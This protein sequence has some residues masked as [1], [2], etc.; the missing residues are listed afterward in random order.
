MI[1]RL[2]LSET[3]FQRALWLVAF[4]FAGFLIGLGRLVVGD[5]Q[6]VAPAVDQEAFMDRAQLVPIRATLK[7]DSDALADNQDAIDR[8]KLAADHAANDY[9]AARETFDNWVA[10]RSATAQSNEN[11]EVLRRTQQLDQLKASERS[12]EKKTEDL[13]QQRLALQQGNQAHQTTL[14]AIQQAGMV[15]Y[16]K[17]LNRQEMRVFLLRLALTLPLL[18]ISIFLFL[19]ARQSTYWPFVWGFILFSLFSFFVEL[20]PYLPSYGGYVRYIVGILLTVLAGVYAIKALNLY[21]SQQK[22]AEELPEA[23]RRKDISYDLALSHLGKKVCPGCE[24][25]FETSDALNNVCMHCGLLVFRNCVVCG[26]RG[27][28]FSNFCR[29]CGTH[30]G[31]VDGGRPKGTAPNID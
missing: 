19:R 16:K 10:T 30:V 21:L 6:L 29:T 24:R 31:D 2:R 5:L 23:E 17:A 13:Q 27:T 28:V 7:L 14:N 26:T 18:L 8:A 4:I 11:P 12:L 9:T 15:G 1:K 20:V 22:A 25:P 3:W